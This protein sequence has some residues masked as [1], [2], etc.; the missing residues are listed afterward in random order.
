[1]LD[2]SKIKRTYFIGIGGIGMSAL[3][4]YF[5]TIGK[6]VAGYDRTA[7][8]LTQKLMEEGIN[9]HFVEDLSLIPEDYVEPRSDTLIIYTPAIPDTNMELKFF[10]N[11]GHNV[12]KR[13]EVLGLITMNSKAIAVAGTH[14]KT[15][16]STIISHILIES[17]I[18][19]NAFLGGISKNFNSNLV[20][21]GKSKYVVVE[22]DE[23]DRS[24][25]QLT[26]TYAVIT[27]CDAD[28]LDIYGDK[29]ELIKTFNYFIEKI[30]PDGILIIKK[31]LE[32]DYSANPDIIVHTY[33]FDEEADYYAKDIMVRHDFYIFDVVTPSGVLRN[34]TIGQTGLMN[35]EN[36]VAA[37]SIAHQ[38][39][40]PEDKI[41]SALYTFLGIKR[42][43]DFQIRSRNLVFIDDY[44]HHPE[45]LKATIKS[46]RKLFPDKRISGI[47]QPHLYS[48]TR[49][50]AE[51][52]AYSLELLDE[53][54]LLD[55]YP[56]REEPI[57][58]VTS[59]LIFDKVNL[60][61]KILCR[62]DELMDVLD[63]MDVEVLITMGAGDI[64]KLVGNIKKMLLVKSKANLE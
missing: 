24:F 50:F 42:R 3:A 26:P 16:V 62:K 22:A 55:I 44:A 23:F 25:L 9:I 20:I 12:L 36:A 59:E 51:E 47:F 15:T 32:L 43:F 21:K 7:T 41:K 33:A 58:G 34:F 5:R 54:V 61:D 29:S 35:V 30:K 11:S 46:A 14:G 45:E 18:S 1:M 31:G 10:M 19:C 49:D 6:K 39:G 8:G 60:E 28:H 56:A 38:L 27:S 2:I 37:I 17:G 57:K 13:S 64:D 4:K 63:Q 53:L 52:F 40:I 48:R